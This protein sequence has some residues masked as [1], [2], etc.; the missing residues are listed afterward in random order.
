MSRGHWKL[1][2]LAAMFLAP[3][4]L[5]AWLYLTDSPLTPSGRTNAGT[6][7]EPIVNLLGDPNRY[8]LEADQLFGDEN[9]WLLIYADANACEAACRDELYRLRQTRRM[10][11]NDM[12]R[13]VR[14]FLHGEN[15]PDTVWL[16][17]QHPGLI[18]IRNDEL[19]GVL[20]QSRPRETG[21]GGLFLVDP[22]G[23]LV[24]HFSR[25]LD[26][27]QMLGDIEHLLELSRI[28]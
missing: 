11:G 13:L 21:A 16:N 18:T 7:L 17:E 25:D 1:A 15:A 24:M 20:T 6:L 2:L 8:G 5:A 28:G 12:S 10:L 26:P 22:L 4:G 9:R 27:G 3:L 14:I 23:N 19:M